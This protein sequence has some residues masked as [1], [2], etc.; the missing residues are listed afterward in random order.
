VEFY[1]EASINL[2]DDAALTRQLV[3]AGFST[4]FIGIETPSAEALGECGKRHN[5]GRDLVAD[6]KRLQRAG[7]EVQGGFIVGFDSDTDDI[8]QRQAE[9]IQRSG[10]TTA[11]VGLLQAPTGTA[12]YAR[13]KGEGRLRGPMSGDNTDDSTN[14]I[15][16]MPLQRLQAGYRRLMAQLYAPSPYYRRVRTFLREYRPGS[17]RPSLRLSH[18]MALGRSMVRLGI[19]GR[20][21]FHYWYLLAWA[22]LRRPRAFPQAVTLAIHGHHFRRIFA[23]HLDHA[24]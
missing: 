23:R 20:E 19:L 5:L 14:I 1:T 12:L 17:S 7:L 18:W 3:D 2:A 9:F 15:P 6:I 10:I 11:M 21:R 13:L 4:V 22:A 16:K 8:F 24:V